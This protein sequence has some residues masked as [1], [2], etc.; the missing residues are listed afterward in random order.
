M[1]VWFLPPPTAQWQVRNLHLSLASEVDCQRPGFT[2]LPTK[3]PLN[4]HIVG[5]SGDGWQEPGVRSR[6]LIVQQFPTFSNAFRL[7]QANMTNVVILIFEYPFCMCNIV[8]ISDRNNLHYSEMNHISV[9]FYCCS[10]KLNSPIIF[11]PFPFISTTLLKRWIRFGYFRRCYLI[12]LGAVS[13]IIS[14]LASRG[15]IFVSAA[16]NVTG[17]FPLIGPLPNR[18]KYSFATGY[19]ATLTR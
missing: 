4:K 10:V 11:H 6:T 14:W 15:S 3:L 5:S 12:C 1:T 8:F 17:T 7:W 18:I 9:L 2:T 19:Y 13:I 16:T